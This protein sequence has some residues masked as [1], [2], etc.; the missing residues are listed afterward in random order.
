MSW[1]SFIIKKIFPKV[2]E[3]IVSPYKQQYELNLNELEDRNNNLKLSL[4]SLTNK[5]LLQFNDYVNKLKE[6]NESHNNMIK[7][8]ENLHKQELD[9]L[10]SEYDMALIKEISNV[11]TNITL[12]NAEKIQGMSEIISSLTDTNEELTEENNNFRSLFGKFNIEL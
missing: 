1:I 6:M 12:E 4:D 10:L 9:N 7:E 2:V 5:N 11:R 8:I 3:D